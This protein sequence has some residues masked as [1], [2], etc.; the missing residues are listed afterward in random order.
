MRG[1]TV[2]ALWGALLAS[3][4]NANSASAEAGA[5]LVLE[6]S[7]TT[8]PALAPYSE[9]A[10]GTRIVL[11]QGARLVFLHYQ[12][13]TTVTVVGGEV[14]VGQASYRAANGSTPIAARTACPAKVRLREQAAPGAGITLRSGP[15]PSSLSTR[16]RFVLVGQGAEAITR[17]RVVLEG[18][19]IVLEGSLT[20][21]EFR[22][23][24]DAAS[25]DPRSEYEIILMSQSSDNRQATVKFMPAEVSSATPAAPPTLIRVE[26]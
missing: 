6:Q 16:P 2:V 24:G 20:G 21:R 10:P 25:L 9:I 11:S 5:A 22:W 23:P 19:G 13:C 4:L 15:S 3:M 14:A 8:V 1:R 17:V 26:D 18:G 7:G 12:T